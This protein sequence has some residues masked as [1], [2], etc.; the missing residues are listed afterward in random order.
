MPRK[1]EEKL[2]K[3]VKLAWMGLIKIFGGEELKRIGPETWLTLVL[4][5]IE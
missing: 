2:T 5:T 1:L 4:K 3:K